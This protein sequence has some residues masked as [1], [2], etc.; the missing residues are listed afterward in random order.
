MQIC[1][2]KEVKVD[3]KV[4]TDLN[5]PAGFMGEYV[6]MNRGR[7]GTTTRRLEYG[8]AAAYNWLL[9]HISCCTDVVQ[10]PKT[11]DQFRLLYNT[12]GR[13][14]LHRLVN[15]DEANYKLC[16][17]NRV[18]ISQKKIPFLVTNDGRTFR[19]PNPA[20]K[21]N[22]TVKVDLTLG[23]ITDYIQFEVGN[24]CMINHGRNTGRV[25]IVQHIERHPG[26]FD[27]VEVKDSAGHVFATRLGNIFIIGKGP[28][29]LI[30]LPRG[31]GIKLSILEEKAVREKKTAQS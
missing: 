5:Y 26:S 21:V 25:G 6:N 29:P 30:T 22:D 19:Y 7:G 23:K 28:R 13:F 15:D 24:L 16:R 27:I 8:A 18:Q 10:I 3:G 12:K 17:V 1:M 31:K 4:R 20:I 9:P 11:S 14:V 2:Q